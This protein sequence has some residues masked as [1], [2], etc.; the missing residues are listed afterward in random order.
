[1]PSYELAGLQYSEDREGPWRLYVYDRLGRGYE[2]RVWFA[3]K[4]KY[5]EEENSIAVAKA[6][7]D[8]AL[9]SGQEVR[10]CDGGDILVYHARGGRVLYGREFWKELA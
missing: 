3:R 10:I 9:A 8:K 5:P 7:V 2:V 6:I 1:M 4:V